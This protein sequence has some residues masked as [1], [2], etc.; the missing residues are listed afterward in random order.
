MALHLITEDL[1]LI[2]KQSLQICILFKFSCVF[3]LEKI[4]TQ[5]KIPDQS[6]T[7]IKVILESSGLCLD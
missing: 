5:D 6:N 2:P 3:H 4:F 7:D 1:K